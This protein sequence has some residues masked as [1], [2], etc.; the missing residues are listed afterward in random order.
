M[1]SIDE[2]RD[3]KAGERE[4]PWERWQRGDRVLYSWRRQDYVRRYI[5]LPRSMGSP[6]K[7][8]KGPR[9]EPVANNNTNGD[10]MIDLKGERKF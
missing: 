4:G 6:K 1:V 5:F 2:R 7:S 8:E 3:G 9:K 10:A